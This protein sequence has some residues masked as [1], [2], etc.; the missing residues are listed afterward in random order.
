MVN[1]C[2]PSYELVSGACDV[3]RAAACIPFIDSPPGL[4]RGNPGC[5]FR[6]CGVKERALLF[7]IGEESVRRLNLL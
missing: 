5:V 6:S 7:Q 2:G 4:L 1:V 3:H